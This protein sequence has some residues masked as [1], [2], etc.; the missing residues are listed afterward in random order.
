MYD[1]MIMIGMGLDIV[2]KAER[3]NLAIMDYSESLKSLIESDEVKEAKNEYLMRC[4]L[5]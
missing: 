3:I 5:T 1:P 4:G 2:L